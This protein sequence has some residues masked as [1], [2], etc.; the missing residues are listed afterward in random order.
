MGRFIFV[1]FGLLVVFLSLSGTGADCPPDWSSYE[2]NCY[3]VVKEKKTWAEAQKFCTEQRKEC[4]L[5][6]FHSAEE[7]DFVVS[8]TFPILSYDLV[9]IGL[10]NIWNDC[11]LEWSDGTKLTYKAWSGIPECIISKTSDNQWLSRACSRTQ[12]FVCKFQA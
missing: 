7:V 5:V 10:N 8:K 4:H 12:P 11:M 9:W 3:L 6:S 2:G 1:S